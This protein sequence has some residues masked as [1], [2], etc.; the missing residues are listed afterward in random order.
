MDIALDKR[1]DKFGKSQLL[2]DVDAFRVSDSST[3]RDFPIYGEGVV[4]DLVPKVPKRQCILINVE[5]LSSCGTTL[6]EI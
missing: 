5:A 2:L 4:W 6:L 3:A 1:P